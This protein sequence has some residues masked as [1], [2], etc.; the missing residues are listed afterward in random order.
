MDRPTPPPNHR[1]GSNNLKLQPALNLN[2]SNL[3]LSNLTPAPPRPTLSSRPSAPNIRLQIP[4]S[5]PRAKISAPSLK[6]DVAAPPGSYY[7]R[8]SDAEGSTTSGS[9]NEWDDDDQ[10]YYGSLNVRSQPSEMRGDLNPTLMPGIPTVTPHNVHQQ[11]RNFDDDENERRKGTGAGAH[12][13]DDVKSYI[14]SLEAERQKSLAAK[15]VDPGFS[16]SGEL[17]SVSSTWRTYTDDSLDE[18][19][20]LGEGAG[21]AVYKVRD[22]ESGLVMAK[23]TIPATNSTPYSGTGFLEG[24]CS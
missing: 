12:S 3:H 5:G 16:D 21:G 18:L 20:R 11:G 6:I 1:S 17:E 9:D 15:V 19:G 4:H 8:G 10:G 7:R 24:L 22:I 23:K 2:L 14:H 13:L